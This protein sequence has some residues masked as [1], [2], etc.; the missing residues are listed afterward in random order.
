[1]VNMAGSS[2][3]FKSVWTTTIM[4]AAIIVRGHA[5]IWNYLKQENI[6]LFNDIYNYPD[7]YVIFP[8][9]TTVTRESVIEDFQGSNLRSLQLIPDSHYPKNYPLSTGGSGQF[10][11]EDYMNWKFYTPAYWRQAWLDYMAGLAKRKYELENNIRYTNVLGF[12]PDNLFMAHEDEWENLRKEMR[13]MDIKNTSF[14]GDKDF[15]DWKTSDF[16]WLA[17]SVAAD[18]YCMRFLDSYLTDSIPNQLTHWGEHTQPCYYQ[19]RNLLDGTQRPAN[20]RQQMVV[21]NV[22][23]PWTNEACDTEIYQRCKAE[24]HQLSL[25]ERYRMCVDLKI[26]PRDYQ[27]DISINNHIPQ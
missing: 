1:M 24:W 20:I 3:W 14:C 11:Y 2:Y 16:L 21:P 26:D 6:K 12:R 19:A 7:W 15:N 17:G 9:T 18:I 22:P 4:K 27:V 23:F 25:D 13:P 5:R 10:S 8:E